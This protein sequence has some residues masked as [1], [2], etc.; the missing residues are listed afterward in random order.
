MA[1]HRFH[2]TTTS[3][4]RVTIEIGGALGDLI[5]EELTAKTVEA[6]A[7][8]TTTKFVL[9]DIRGLTD[10]TVMARVGLGTCQKLLRRRQIR[11]AWLVSTPR[12]H[13]LA[14]LVTYSAA[15]DGAGVFQTLAQAEAWFAAK[16][17]T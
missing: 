2:F 14:T 17:S 9:L 10:F 16:K 15:D 4:D 6:L 7:N 11:T 3:P 1:Q 12:Q 8:Q 5:A 13:G